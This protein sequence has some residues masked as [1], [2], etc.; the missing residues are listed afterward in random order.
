MDCNTRQVDVNI[1][2]PLPDYNSENNLGS[3]RQLFAA[4]MG[5]RVK[6]DI[7]MLDGS[8]RSITGDIYLV[9]NAYVGVSCD[10]KLL[11]GDVYSIKFATFF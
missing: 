4:N 2:D 3:W 6:I 9:G 8:L 1:P 7:A 10:G 11:F 5:K